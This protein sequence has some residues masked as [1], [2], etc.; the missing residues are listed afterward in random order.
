[1][2]SHEE[3]C[4]VSRVV[5]DGISSEG[6][7]DAVA[8]VGLRREVMLEARVDEESMAVEAPLIVCFHD[9]QPPLSDSGRDMCGG[10]GKCVTGRTTCIVC[11]RAVE[12]WE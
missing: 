2:P 11:V 10:H 7:A 3:D 5:T 9:S 1:M 4:E 8:D 12:K 6:W